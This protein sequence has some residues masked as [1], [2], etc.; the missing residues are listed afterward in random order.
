MNVTRVIIEKAFGIVKTMIYG[1]SGNAAEVNASNELKVSAVVVAPVPLPTG[2]ATAA[3]QVLQIAQETAI[4]GKD[5]A[6]QTTLATRALETGG[7]LE[8]AADHVHSI[9]GKITACNT[10]AVVVSSSALPSGAATAVAQA[11]QPQSATTITEYS[12]TCT[13]ANTEYSQALP[14][15]TRRISFQGR[16][17][18][19]IRFAFA[20]GK[21]A[22]SVEPFGTLAAGQPFNESE[23]DLSSKTLYVASS[24]AGD[25]VEMKCWT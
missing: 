22:T 25:V 23:L 12:I 19:S 24:T 10:G 13:V 14:A 8:E 21:V 6:T 16:S 17:Y 7:H 18:A 20:P 4:A 9:D 11:A 1:A 2:S 15:N 3:N 5:F